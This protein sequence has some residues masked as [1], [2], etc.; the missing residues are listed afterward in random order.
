MV[1][2]FIR[3]TR[4]LD[5]KVVERVREAVYKRVPVELFADVDKV[6]D[7]IRASGGC[8]R[9]LLRLLQEALLRAETQIGP[10]EVR[11]AVQQVG[12]TYQRL[13]RS[14]DDLQILAQAHLKH[15]VLSDERTQYLLHHLCLL[16]YNG[17]GW[18]DFHPLLDNYAPVKDAV[19]A[20]RQVN[21]SA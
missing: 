12:Q 14:S 17:E 11:A 5:A 4:R 18:Y 10:G 2:I 6:D 13:L 19:E 3:N 20:A 21:A 8:W 15:T 1:P 7:L 9:D 16:S